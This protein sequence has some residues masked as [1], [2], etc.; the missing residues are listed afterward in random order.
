MSSAR[1]GSV[2]VHGERGGFPVRP[3]QVQLQDGIVQIRK[4]VGD[5]GARRVVEAGE[6]EVVRNRRRI[7]HSELTDFAGRRV[8]EGVAKPKGLAALADEK[9]DLAVKFAAGF[10]RKP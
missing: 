2:E 3:P 5:V 9:L 6:G 7:F 10:A 4:G 1:G 8:K